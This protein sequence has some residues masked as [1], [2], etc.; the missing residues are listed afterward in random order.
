VLPDVFD[1]MDLNLTS[2]EDLNDVIDKDPEHFE[3]MV[4]KTIDAT[5]E[6]A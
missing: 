5:E 2:P 4:K 3:L 6:T 1:K